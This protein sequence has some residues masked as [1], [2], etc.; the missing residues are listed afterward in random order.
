M[1]SLAL[2]GAHSLLGMINDLLDVGKIE[3]GQMVLER[4]PIDLSTVAHAAVDQVRALARAKRIRLIED[5][6][7][8]L[9]TVAADEEKVRRVLV[10]LLGNAIKFTPEKGEVAVEARRQG[11]A[12]LVLVRDTGEGIPEEHRER[13]FE[14][15]GQVETRQSGRT[16]S[17]GLGLTFCKMVVEAHGGR[18]W[19]ESELQKGSTLSFVIPLS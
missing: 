6:P 10:N 11:E 15:F 18:I 8:D 16:M 4:S 12:I 13:I 17:T 2:S 7:S 14:K 1:T 19:V 9:G 3:A 5:L